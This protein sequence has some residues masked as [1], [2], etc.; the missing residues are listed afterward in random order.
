[1]TYLD[2]KQIYRKYMEFFEVAE[3]KRRWS[4]FDDLPWELA[5]GL[6]PDPDAV[7]CAET[8][9]AV[10]S[11]MPDYVG[12]GLNLV[13]ESFGQA[14]WHVNWGYEEAKHALALREYLVRTGQRTADQMVDFETGLLNR[15]WT[16]PFTTVRRMVCYGALQE[17]TTWM[18]Y[19]HRLAAARA[20][21]D[22]LLASIYRYISRDEA[23][24]GGFYL[25]VIGTCLSE[26]RDGTVADLQ[27][28]LTRFTMPAYDLVPDYEERVRVMRAIGI[29]RKIFLREVLLPILG[30]LGVDRRELARAA[31][32]EAA[33]AEAAAEAA[34]GAQGGQATPRTR[35]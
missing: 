15:R 34:A 28:V 19:R 24:H 32:A 16:L 3:R 27:H 23:A 30:R 7:L 13:R 21:G 29:T 33:A 2:E 35:A 12:E 26:D 25:D 18:I 20:A 9:C 5:E 8:F 11:Y 22:A 14:W 1:M 10:E 17:K 31:A 4:V 6:D